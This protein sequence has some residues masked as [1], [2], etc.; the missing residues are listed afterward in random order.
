M[1]SDKEKLTKIRL[2]LKSL[3]KE[4]QDCLRI[5]RGQPEERGEQ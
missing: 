1:N 5:L 3:E 4:L 2:F